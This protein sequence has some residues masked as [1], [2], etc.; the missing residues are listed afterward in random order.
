MIMATIWEEA[1][2]FSNL[3]PPAE[4]R[5][6][7]HAAEI[8]IL[9]SLTDDDLEE[10]SVSATLIED[11][12]D[13][14]EFL[15]PDQRTA[16]GQ[17]WVAGREGGRE[18]LPMVM[19]LIPENSAWN[20][21]LG[22]ALTLWNPVLDEAVLGT[23]PVGTRVNAI[24]DL[25]GCGFTTEDSQSTCLEVASGIAEGRTTALEKGA[26]TAGRVAATGLTAWFGIPGEPV[27]D[28]AY[29]WMNGAAHEVDDW[30]LDLAIRYFLAVQVQEF[31]R[32]RSGVVRREFFDE[33]RRLGSGPPRLAFARPEGGDP[34][35]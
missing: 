31:D 28:R 16:F 29:S 35:R 20:V 2:G 1:R 21:V 9:T 15:D 8:A 7:L 24:L 23:G 10:C 32:D 33:A 34:C 5:V 22:L 17:L 11:E 13:R 26:M 3:D 25:L 30:V 4:I 6:A 12:I 18:W 14:A 27:I 19:P